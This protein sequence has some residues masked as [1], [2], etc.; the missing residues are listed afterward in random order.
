MT[1]ATQKMKASGSDC[2]FWKKYLKIKAESYMIVLGA[3][4][5]RISGKPQG[6]TY[7]FE[8]DRLGTIFCDVQTVFL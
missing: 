4:N 8:A 7:R 5:W 6:S 3:C 2:L 1:T